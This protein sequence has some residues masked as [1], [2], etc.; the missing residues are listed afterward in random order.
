MA[1]NGSCHCGKVAYTL[2]D[3]P[4][5]AMEC[6]C[7]IC[8]RKG[9]VLAFSSHDKFTLHTPRE[10]LTVYTFGKHAIRHQFCSTCGCAAFGEG[11]GST[12]PMVAVNLRCAEDFDLSALNITKFD[13]ANLA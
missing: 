1:I 8:R 10:A 7:S 5:E 4:T 13:G 9:Y 3:E 6:N 12:G 11:D 2:D